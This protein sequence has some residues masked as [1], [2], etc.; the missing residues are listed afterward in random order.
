MQGFRRSRVFAVITLSLA[1][2][3]GG[4]T[5]GRGGG[6]G[7]LT[8]VRLQLQWVAQSQF[9]G[10]YAAAAKGYYK[11]AGLEVEIKLGGPD[12]VPQQVV[13]SDGAEFGI[14]WVPEMLASREARADLVNI[15]QALQRSGTPEVSIKEKTTTAPEQRKCRKAGPCA[16]GNEP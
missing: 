2:A 7:P 1:S 10:Y 6:G 14:A 4:G 15:A 12:I 8:K 9:A 11:D 16:V 5:G 13:A 3:C